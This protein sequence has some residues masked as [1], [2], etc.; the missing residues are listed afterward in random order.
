MQVRALSAAL[1]YLISV[2]KPD[3]TTVDVVD[4]ADYRG[5]FAVAQMIDVQC[6]ADLFY[7]MLN[8]KAGSAIRVCFFS[9]RI[10]DSISDILYKSRRIVMYCCFYG[11]AAGVPHHYYQVCSQVLYSVLD[12]PQLMIVDNISGHSDYEQLSDSCR[13]N[14]LRNNS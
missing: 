3:F 14:T 13:K 5:V 2:Q 10:S 12:A 1:S 9:D 8:I 4:R 6:V 11:A 7:T